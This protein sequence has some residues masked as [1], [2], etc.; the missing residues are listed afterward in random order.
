M[1][2]LEDLRD[3]A[4]F[5][6][7]LQRLQECLC[8]ELEK[9][10]GP[11]LCFCGLTP[12][13]SPPIGIMDCNAKTCGVAWVTPTTIFPTDTFPIPDELQIS[14]C[15]SQIALSFEIGVARCYPR[16]QG[17]EAQ[18][19]PQAYFD[20]LRLY[21][22]DMAAVRRAIICCF[23]KDKAVSYTHLTLPTIYSV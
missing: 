23:G 15:T 2:G 7:A 19:D 14:P 8:S 16:P 3:E 6:P 11:D 18:A 12:A 13:G 17:R 5:F 9:A 1:A 20:A 21:L 22:S 4:R 10:G